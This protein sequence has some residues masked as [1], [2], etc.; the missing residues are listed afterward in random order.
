[1]Q[2]WETDLS[3]SPLLHPQLTICLG[4]FDGIHLGHQQLLQK[5]K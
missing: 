4:Y 3:T 1:M 5:A 2:I